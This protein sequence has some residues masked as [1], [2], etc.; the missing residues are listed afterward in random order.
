MLAFCACERRLRNFQ[1]KAFYIPLGFQLLGTTA[2][3]GGSA[4]HA[5]A[6]ISKRQVREANTLRR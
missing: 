5:G 3:D 2:M 6:V 1:P 4:G